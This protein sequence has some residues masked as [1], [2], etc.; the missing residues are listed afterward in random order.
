MALSS[1]ALITLAEAKSY[2][3]IETATHGER[4]KVTNKELTSNVATLTTAQAH[5]L[6]VN[7]TAYVANVDSTFDGT[8]TV[9]AVGSSKTFSYAK[10]AGNV[11]STAVTD[12]TAEVQNAT[13]DSFLESLIESSTEEINDKTGT[14]WK[15]ASYTETYTVRPEVRTFTNGYAGTYE[16]LYLYLRHRPLISLTSISYDEGDTTEDID[17]STSCYRYTEAEL[18]NIGAIYCST[19]WPV[20]ERVVTVT[21]T[22][23][24][25]SVPY[26][27]QK[28][29]KKMVALEYWKSSHG[30]SSLLVDQ[31]QAIGENA[32]GESFRSLEELADE[33]ENDLLPF[34]PMNV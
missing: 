4:F 17:E 1:A 31:A 21:Y 9:T 23:G 8:H 14:A 22:A 34:I 12:E 15:S 28:L 30:R 11:A 16:P 5:G 25:A 26:K 33:I 10:T 3:K 29:C 19:G 24:Y 13:I 7:D 32:P 2:L 18:K 20:G 27:I 6:A